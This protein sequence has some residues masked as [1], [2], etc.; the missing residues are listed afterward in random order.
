MYVY[1]YIYICACVRVC[2]C[3]GMFAHAYITLVTFGKLVI[4]FYIT[5]FL[6]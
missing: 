4:D 3:V 1:I 6:F 2:V 5:S